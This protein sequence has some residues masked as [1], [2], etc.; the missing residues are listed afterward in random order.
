[1]ERQLLIAQLTV[2]LEQRAAQHRLR[3]KPLSSGLLQPLPPQVLRHQSKQVAMAVQP[4]RHRLQLAAD[5]VSGKEIEYAGLDGA[6]DTH[7]RLRRF[8]LLFGISGLMP[9]STRNRRASH[10][11]NHNSSNNINSLTFMDGN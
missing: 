8:G 10:L 11:K 7:Y 5:L 4:F 2:L 6:F 1:M 3:R 9:K